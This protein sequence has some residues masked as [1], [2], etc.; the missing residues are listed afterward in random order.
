[1]KTYASLAVVT[2]TTRNYFHRARALMDNVEKFLPGAVRLTAC[3]DDMGEEIPEDAASIGYFSSAAMG[4][5]RYQQL[6]FALNPTALC[7]ALKAHVVNRA[8]AVNGITRVLYLDNDIGLYRTPD[9]ILQMLEQHSVVLTPH[10]LTPLPA[11][12]QP[13]EYCLIPYGI[14]N[15][16]MFA[17]RK[18]EQAENFMTWWG[19]WLMDPRHSNGHWGY[20]QV[21]LNYVPV[22]CPN[23]GILRDPGYNVAFWNLPERNLDVNHDS[24]TCGSSPLTAFHFSHF[25]ERNPSVLVT[26][27]GI[28]NLS[29]TPATV[30]LGQCM[31][32]AWNDHGR[33]ECLSWGYGYQKW[34]DGSKVLNA[35]REA[36]SALWDEIP[37]DLDLWSE[38]FPRDHPHL[39]KRIKAP[40]PKFSVRLSGALRRVWNKVVQSSPARN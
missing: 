22:Y 38:S 20:D 11:N 5:P 9:E 32:D 26:K 28:T 12:S 13:D 8:L 2:V 39:F 18:C 25:D 10:H 36:A 6:A 1:M 23:Y 7:C 15:A 37:H 16:G 31:A 34:P 24:F 27:K 29:A 4:L 21:W 40:P 33:S 35:E 3:V 14:F 30:A 17:V 19:G